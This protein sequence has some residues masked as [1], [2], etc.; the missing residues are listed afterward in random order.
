MLDTVSDEAFARYVKQTGMAAPDQIETARKEAPLPLGEALVKLGVITAQQRET[1]EKKL[2]AQREGVGELG[3]CR[4]LKKLGEG[5]MG[6]VYLAE[7]TARSRKVAIKVL[8]KKHAQ[9]KE[10]LKRFRR[11]AEA[12]AR[13][14]HPNIVQGFSAGEDRGYHFYVME[15]CEGETLRR[16]IDRL[17]V[18]PIAD[19]CGL[20]AQVARGLKYAHDQGFIHRDVKPENVVVTA[21]GTAK[22]LDLGLAKNLEDT[23]ATFRTVTGAA[24][25]TPHYI[26]PEQARGDKQVDGRSDIYSLGATFYHLVTGRTP[27]QGSSIFEVIQKHLME[28]LADPRDLRPEV[29]EGVVHVIRR[30]LAKKPDDRYR[31]CGDLINDLERLTAK[32]APLSPPIDPALSSLALPSSSAAPAAR[33]TWV[34]IG[35]AAAAGVLAIV[36]T[37]LAWPSPK[38]PEVPPSKPVVHVPPPKVEPKPAEPIAKEPERPEPV[39]ADPPKEEPKPEPPKPEPPKPEPAK[40]EPEPEKPKPEPPKPDPVRPPRVAPPVVAK[41][42]AAEASLKEQYK[43]DLAKPALSD[44]A[45]LGRKLLALEPP[46]DPALNYERL[47]YARDAAAQGGDPATALGAVDRMVE[48]FVVDGLALKADA[49][50]ACPLRTTDGAAAVATAAL[51][52]LDEA[53][54]SDRYDVTSRL[55]PKAKTAGDLSK[56]DELK[57]GAAT[58]EKQATLFQREFQGVSGYAE[59]LKT[60]PDDGPANSQ[61]GRFVCFVKDDWERGLAMLAKGN[62]AGLKSLAQ[63]ELA[64]PEDAERQRELCEGWLKLAEG[65]TKAVRKDTLTAR[66]RLWFDLVQTKLP[67]VDRPKIAKRL[68]ALEKAAGSKPAASKPAAKA[69]GA[70]VPASLPG[71]WLSLMPIVDVSRHSVN[72][73]WQ[74]TPEGLVSPN[75]GVNAGPG[76]ARIWIPYSVPDEYELILYVERTQGT[77]DLILG[78]TVRGKPVAIAIDGWGAQ[79]ASGAY[80]NG[81][82]TRNPNVP[83]H[84]LQNN[85]VTRIGCFVR[86]GGLSVTIEGRPVMGYP[87]LGPLGMPDSVRIPGQTDGLI[88]GS[89]R[90]TY[91]VSRIELLPVSG[92]P[93]KVIR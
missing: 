61:M 33:K 4:L 21:S 17:K 53:L 15:Y 39:K 22:L 45:A 91:R 80:V 69:G 24:L 37:V 71:G 38:P 3:G 14:D 77:E 2:E 20:V 87:D 6:A 88:I 13:L 55:L 58:R 73:A 8:P 50:A 32:Q 51:A 44:K 40:P 46:E 63:L 23:N 9:D 1:V 56:N 19:A 10:F 26:S 34:W 41:L 83:A 57:A 11:E 48:F 74:R 42:R 89:V 49:L 75:T 25:G 81:G 79:G 90:S 62:E 54:Q 29:P 47:L 28:R 68:E 12:A 93:G 92:G 72:G 16:R 27:F 70:A 78:L 5:G 35:S 64:R 43:E 84:P 67:D 52:I 76:S 36:V 65:E 30:M 82:W 18:L 86:G 85:R 60:K 66:A 31:D 59:T 7:E